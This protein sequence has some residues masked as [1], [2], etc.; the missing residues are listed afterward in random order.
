[1][2]E[3][4]LAYVIIKKEKLDAD[5][6]QS[7]QIQVLLS[8]LRRGQKGDMHKDNLPRIKLYLFSVSGL[9]N[10]RNFLERHIWK[11]WVKTWMI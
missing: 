10:L 3:L 6:L 8:K 4:N 9:I 2:C 7:A 11:L 1:M 5:V